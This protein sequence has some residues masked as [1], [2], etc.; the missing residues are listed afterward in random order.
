MS[1]VMDDHEAMSEISALPEPTMNL[2]SKN[3]AQ[4]GLKLS[5]GFKSSGMLKIRRLKQIK[6]SQTVT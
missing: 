6:F 1:A 5:L 2:S 4:Y 3:L